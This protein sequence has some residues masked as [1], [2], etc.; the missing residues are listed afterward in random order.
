MIDI[1]SFYVIMM[2]I[3]RKIVL[4]VGLA[5]F[6]PSQSFAATLP[7]PVE[8]VFESL[9][10][11]RDIKVV[12]YIGDSIMTYIDME[13]HD[14]LQ[15]DCKWKKYSESSIK[16]AQ[17]LDPTYDSWEG[18][19]PKIGECVKM[20]DY[21]Y[22]GNRILFAR[23]E[24]GN[25]RFWDP[26]SIPFSNSVFFFAKEGICKPTDLCLND[27][28]SETEFQCSDGFLIAEKEFEELRNKR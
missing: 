8:K 1:T 6:V 26:Q 11:I 15:L 14:T 21:K 2:T 9:E 28:Q 16:L 17:E 18:T 27:N 23:K 13:S 24:N 4:I 22:G 10:Q 20:L 12:N 5:L 25:Y 7:I 3:S 19:F